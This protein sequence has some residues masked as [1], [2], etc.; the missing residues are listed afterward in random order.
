MKTKSRS[1]SPPSVYRNQNAVLRAI[2]ESAGDPRGVLCVALDYAKGKHKALVC[3]GRGD[4]LK[5]PLPVDNSVEGLAFLLSEVA[6]SARR[7]GIDAKHIFFGGE[8]E[9]GYAANFIAGLHAAGFAVMRV[10]AFEAKENRANLTA[11][12]DD[13][14]LLGIAKT[15]LSRRARQCQGGTA[16]D[17]SYA[18][19]RELS[20]LRHSFV[21]QKTATAN[22]I[23]AL[24][25]QLLPGFLDS[26][27]SGLTPFCAA[28][29]ELMKERFSTVEMARRRQAPLARLL[30]EHGVASPG[31]AA[32][33]LI[34]L[35]AGA[36]PPEPGRV[37]GLQRALRAAVDLYVCLD[38]N[39]KALRA[40][41]AQ[42]LALT[43]YA[44]LT[45][46]PGI[47]FVLSAGIA[48]ELGN[49]SRLGP[50][51][52]LCGYAGIVGK[53][54]Q[55]GG[56]DKPA[57]QRG[58]SKR[59]NH[60]LKNWVVQGAE[61]IRLYGTPELRGRILAWQANGQ[62]HTFAAARRLLRLVRALVLNGVPYL[63]PEGRGAGAAPQDTAD[64][65]RAA[66]KRLRSK[67]RTIPGGSALI[68]DESHPV[69]FWR[70]VVM[71]LHGLRLP[72]RDSARP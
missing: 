64:A 27:R 9:P 35:A 34:A 15:L 4:I 25:D 70:R 8:D 47:G 42:V 33:K 40:E 23:H 72:A 65:A 67:W 36:L 20:R 18:R 52:S 46:I 58:P 6:A 13:L 55:T 14:D 17:A 2:F 39:S 49:P 41:A 68:T 71:E 5:R 54:A 43:P 10:N 3:N 7:A 11:S 57:R 38:E 28:S 69:G 37:C 31:E 45:S 66:W 59:C 21:C 50:T 26:D 61:K 24:V 56:P 48:A 12:T 44:M 29:L 32:A 1:V 60:L 63:D 22:R 62:H 53:T 19:L 16:S 30:E 51:D